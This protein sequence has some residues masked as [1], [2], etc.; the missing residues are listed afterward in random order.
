MALQEIIDRH[1]S[2]NVT[3]DKGEA[4]FDISKIDFDLLHREFEKAKQ[5]NLLVSELRDVIDNRLKRALRN[6]PAGADFYEQYQRIIDA[7]NS[8]QDRA[9]IEATFEALVK[10]SE[11]LSEEEQRFVREGFTDER[12]LAV[13][14][15]LCKDSLTKEEIAQVKVLARELADKIQERLSQM[16]R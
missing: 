15:M 6:N 9:S 3:E 14:D 2:V 5:N 11:D 7:Y 1:I 10:L 4:R 16:T 12:Q 13:F 8:E